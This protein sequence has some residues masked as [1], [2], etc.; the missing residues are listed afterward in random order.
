MP[1][2]YSCDACVP[3]CQ[4]EY[5][6]LQ[7]TQTE[8][9]LEVQRQSDLKVLVLERQIKAVEETLEKEQLKLWVALAFGQGDQT[10]AENIKVWFY[11]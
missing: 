1:G 2:G 10:A 6:E 3:Q 5:E 7:K 11:I 8:A 9:T 4:Q